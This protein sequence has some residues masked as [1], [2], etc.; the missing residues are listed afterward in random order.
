[1]LIGFSLIIF[2]QGCITSNFDGGEIFTPTISN[3]YITEKSPTIPMTQGFITPT[4]MTLQTTSPT[5]TFSFQLIY[6]PS[7]I[8]TLKS[9]DAKIL[10]RRM[11]AQ[12]DGCKLPCWWGITPGETRW[13]DAREMLNSFVERIEEETYLKQRADGSPYMIEIAYVYF[14]RG[15]PEPPYSENAPGYF[16]IR[17]INGIVESILAYQDTASRYTLQKLL[18]ENGPP[19]NVYINT[20]SASPTG[21][22]PFNLLVDFSEKGFMAFY[23]DDAPIIGDTIYFCPKDYVPI[24][25]LVWSPSPEI[26][27]REKEEFIAGLDY[28]IYDSGLLPIQD[29]SN[30]T[31]E[32]FYVNFRNDNPAC[33]VTSPP[34]WDDLTPSFYYDLLTSTPSPVSPWVETLIPVTP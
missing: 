5:P 9:E 17:S 19:L 8:P 12:N 13:V 33:I 1:M 23:H 14:E 2:L 16:G 15:V 26:N 4:I 32:Q 24:K 6:T 7:F 21:K 25:I 29:V 34:I 30:L 18:T 22:V 20:T 3:D 28:W 27:Q 31:I 11:L 10:F